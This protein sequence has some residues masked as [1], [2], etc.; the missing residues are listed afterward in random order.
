MFP[1]RLLR[2]AAL[3]VES[4]NGEGA[5]N[6]ARAEPLVAKAAQDG[7]RLVLCPEFLATGY[8]YDESIWAS[9]ESRAG[10]T[11]SWLRRLAS[12]HG[13]YIGA[14]YLEA[15][16]EDFFNTFALAAPDGRIAGRVRKESLPAFE[17]WYFKSSD[18]PKTIE[19]EI[20]RIAVGICQ[21]NHTA[22]FFRRVMRDEPD[23]IL[24]PHSAP[25]VPIGTSVFREQLRAIAQ[26]YACAFGVPVVLANKIFG[27]SQS[28]V[29][30]VPF[31]RAPIVY[32]GGSSVCDSD[33]RVA[34]WMDDH[35]GVAIGGVAL[36]PARKSRPAAPSDSYWSRPPRRFRRSAAALLIALER[37]GM[38]AYA[39]SA[40][41]RLAARNVSFA[42][43]P[44]V[45][46]A[47][48]ARVD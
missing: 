35:E 34:A 17:G 14:S 38:R 13:I 26:H 25:R 15:E 42:K 11:E 28:P 20:G 1:S 45:V 41:R 27:R 21:D 22:C 4:R 30:G 18:E 3:Q 6:L 9:G 10:I 32:R 47:A 46:A 8:L 23:L 48:Y 7:A 5:S 19:T 33:G 24:M 39:K 36:D 16:G 43:T 31:V 29:P 2:V 40:A 44:V 12:E 37:A